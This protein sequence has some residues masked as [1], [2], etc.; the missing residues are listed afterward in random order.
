MKQ[1]KQKHSLSD[2]LNQ[3]EEIVRNLE[4]SDQVD[5]EKSLEEYK[6]GAKL[7][8]EIKK[9][10]KEFTIEVEKVEIGEEK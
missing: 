5:L 2:K 6:L 1:G 7:A 10:L 8:K 9:E 4:S 3:L